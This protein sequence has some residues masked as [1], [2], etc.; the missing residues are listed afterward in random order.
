MCRGVAATLLLVAGLAVGCGGQG[1]PTSVPAPAAASGVYRVGSGLEFANPNDALDRCH[2][3]G[4]AACRIEVAAGDYTLRMT[5]AFGAK[6]VQFEC[7]GRERT[8]IHVPLG[9]DGFK[10]TSGARI[11]HCR[12][13][14]PYAPSPGNSLIDM[15]PS[16]GVFIE[17]NEIEGSGENGI[18]TGRG[19]THWVIA[20]NGV[21]HALFDGVF[22]GEGSSYN[23]VRGNIITRNAAIGVDVNG[24]HNLI[25]DNTLADN[26]GEGR[27]YDAWGIL[28]AGMRPGGHADE[29]DVVDNVVM[30]SGS[31]GI[32][33]RAKVGSTASGN[34]IGRNTVS[35]SGGRAA[36]NGDGISIDGT[37]GGALEANRIVDNRVQH[38]RRHGIVVDGN[39]IPAVRGNRVERN[40]VM[41]SASWSLLVT[42]GATSTV[43][44][45]NC[46]DGPM[47]DLGSETQ[48]SGNGL[49][50]CA[51]ANRRR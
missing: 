14:G 37:S 7:A 35:A 32:I 44:L 2:A 27:A 36:T 19:S 5:L 47:L 30:R 26:G 39:G 12:I 23:V 38:S 18:N 20:G 34:M 22:L 40:H 17:D 10:P 21:H 16:D 41:S 9:M 6:V 42:R 25:A 33:V 51:T 49:G 4:G 29:N 43:A 8:T 15:G 28:L 1:G 45:D 50:A 48:S 11:A 31:Q 3:D 13:V 46:L 24:S